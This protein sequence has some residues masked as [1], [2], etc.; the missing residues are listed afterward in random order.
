[1]NTPAPRL[2]PLFR[3][4]TQA[5]ILARL[6]LNP[7][8]SYTTAELARAASAPYATAH[9]E[10]QRLI[11]AGLL[12]QEKVGRAIRLSANQSDPA[13]APVGELLRL[14]Y[15]P[16]VVVPRVLAGLAGIQEAY[17]Y[18]SWAARREG[19]RGSPPGDIDVLVV[20]N[21]PRSEIHDAAAHAEQVL[22]R[23][24]NI[25]LVSP[26]AWREGTDL[27]VKTVRDRPRIRLDLQENS[28]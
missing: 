28:W 24:V 26:Q 1:M 3:S 22:G 13:F 9:R 20:G 16:A 11:D 7:D 10:V 15:G 4:D 14:S 21:P 27:F 8:R 23:E 17:L 18:G 2:S 19:E 25:R 6:I 5:E 12:T